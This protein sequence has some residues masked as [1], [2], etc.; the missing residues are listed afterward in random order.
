MK[1]VTTSESIPAADH[2]IR[3]FGQPLA[4]AL[5]CFVLVALIFVMGAMNLQ[6]LDDSL[7]ELMAKNGLT[8]IGDFNKDVGHSFN[9][10]GAVPPSSTFDL[11]RGTL[12]DQDDFSL[13]EQFLNSL[14]DLSR[15]VDRMRDTG[16][17]SDEAFKSYLATERLTMVVFFDEEGRVAL[18]NRVVPKE[19]LEV[20]TPVIRGEEF[21]K[22]NMFMGA[23]IRDTYAFI[24]LRRSSGEG[25][26]I[27]VLN[28]GD[29]RYQ[30]IRFSIQMA[31]RELGQPASMAYLLA[32][33][34]TG[35]ILGS[36][37]KR[38]EESQGRAETLTDQIDDL[39]GDAAIRKATFQDQNFLEI[40]APLHVD[41][42]NSGTVRLGLNMDDPLEILRKSR[43]NVFFSAGFMM[44]ITVLAVGFIYRIQNRYLHKIQE[45]DRRIQ[46]AE[47]LSALGQFAAGVAHEIRNPLNAISIAIQRLQRESPHRLTEVIRDE[48]SRLN[49]IVE[50][51]LSVAKSRKL[52][53]RPHDLK[54]L[55]EQILLLGEEE[56]S[57][58]GILITTHWPN[59]PVMI[60]MDPQR[61]KQA[62]LNIAKNA[63]ESISGKGSVHIDLE[64]KGRKWAS[65]RF[66]DTGIGLNAGE[67]E[68]VFDLGYTTKDK[69]LGFGL[70]LAHEIIQGHGGTIRVSS[71]R[72]R[73][74]VF[75][76]LLP[77]TIR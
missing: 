26:E 66:T 5:L 33:D 2:R 41:G 20:A 32:V 6:T 16:Q 13:E 10:L 54:E 31:L 12:I 34:Q 25:S 49:D 74:T 48:I 72:G 21:F 23:Q 36:A 62:F 65:V 39:P 75:E 47:R 17:L 44:A 70:P 4:L 8:I 37:G 69:G 7:V 14:I 28:Q 55:L 38:F 63:L 43:R 67:L 11:A 76:I 56:A 68:H 42:K 53:L 60:A 29:F 19:L 64:I 45:K 15:D 18:T 27:L 3:T 61:L 71:D 73:G 77:L 57:Q 46:M 30:R 1:A 58:K 22:T 35:R 52:E 9:R 50:E 40:T 24:A 59:T 51:F